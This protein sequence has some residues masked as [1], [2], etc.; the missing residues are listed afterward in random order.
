MACRLVEMIELLAGRRDDVAYAIVGPGDA[1][2][3][4]ALRERGLD[5]IVDVPGVVTDDDLLRAYMATADVCLSVD[6]ANGMNDRSTMVKVLEYMAMALPVV[7]IDVPA[8]A[9]IVRP[10]IDGLLYPEG[11]VAALVRALEELLESPEH[12]RSLGSSARKRAVEE[13]SWRRHCGALDRI[14]RGLAPQ[15]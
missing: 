2:V 11:D 10:G 3:R 9:A 7:T 5:G 14:L 12:A 4:A 13:F 6:E 8:L 1:G 15:S